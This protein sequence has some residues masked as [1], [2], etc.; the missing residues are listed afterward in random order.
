M[1]PFDRWHRVMSIRGL[2]P[3]EK[4]VLTAIACHADEAGDAHPSVTTIGVYASVSERTVQVALVSL[5]AKGLLVVTPVP[6]FTARLRCNY[7]AWPDRRA[8]GEKL[9]PHVNPH[10]RNRRTP[11]PQPLRGKGTGRGSL[12]VPSQGARARARTTPTP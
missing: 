8:K 7:D 1:S 12:K 10:P 11:P 4:S 6:G 3:S 9:A 5:A 2:L